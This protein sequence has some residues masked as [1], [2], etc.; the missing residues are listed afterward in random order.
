MKKY[1][2]TIYVEFEAE[3]YAIAEETARKLADELSE[4]AWPG[5]VEEVT[6]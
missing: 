2:V 5:D 1:E 6:E 3:D 4:H